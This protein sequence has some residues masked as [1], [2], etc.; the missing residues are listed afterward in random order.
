MVK[1]KSK[2][3]SLSTRSPARCVRKVLLYSTQSLQ[4]PNSV[5]FYSLV[6]FLPFSANHVTAQPMGGLG[7]I[8]KPSWYRLLRSLN[9]ARREGRVALKRYSA[10][11]ASWA[12]Y[13]AVVRLL[14]K[15]KGGRR[16]KG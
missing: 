15:Y 2:V 6:L 14:L 3:G 8:E 1:V 16:R 12:G 10:L 11:W 5:L 4:S 13:E 7:Q 9:G